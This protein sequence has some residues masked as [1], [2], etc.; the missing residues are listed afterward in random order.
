VAIEDVAAQQDGV[1]TA[2]EARRYGLTPRQVQHRV[3]TGKWFRLHPR[4]YYALPGEPSSAAR[5]RGAVAWAGEGAVASGLSAAFWWELIDW[6]PAATE[7]T[8]PRHRSSRCPP[9]VLVRRAEL[10][11]ADRVLVRGLPVTALPTTVL[12]AAILLGASEGG[13][14]LDRSL[15]RRVRFADLHEAYCRAIGRW[16]TPAAGQLLTV[17]ADRA[18]S[19]A[20]RVTVRLLRQAGITGWLLNS[21]VRA[22][23]REYIVDVVFPAA[24]VAVE[25]DGWA[26]HSGVERFRGDRRRQNALVLAGWTVLRFTWDDLV[27]RPG[28][29]VAE[30]RR[31]VG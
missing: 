11:P 13:R 10:D 14:L 7:V 30:I 18:A 31:A 2:A 22:G 19:H 9:T 16:G 25:I 28:R 15:Q 8:V 6:T 29:V 4:V 20:E 21:P 17:V 27:S 3:R 23:D 12:T 5:I 24:R 26:W 1:V